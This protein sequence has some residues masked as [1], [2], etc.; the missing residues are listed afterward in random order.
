MFLKEYNE[1]GGMCTWLRRSVPFDSLCPLSPLAS[2]SV[3]TTSILGH[4]HDSAYFVQYGDSPRHLIRSETIYRA[5]T[6]EDI[7]LYARNSS[8]PLVM[9]GSSSLLHSLEGSSI[10]A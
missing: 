7:V 4:W 2:Y 9:R 5:T 10:M 8:D 6:Y 1:V 3:S